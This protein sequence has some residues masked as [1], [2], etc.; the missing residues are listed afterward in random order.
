VDALSEVL[1]IVK[2]EGAF[3]FN[4]EFSSPWCVT[5]PCAV[6]LVPVLAPGSAHLITFH[7]LTEGQCTVQVQGEAEVKL[8]AGDIIIIPH[9]DSHKL[10]NGPRSTAENPTGQLE[11]ILEHGLAPIRLGGGGEMTRFVCGYMTC[12]AHICDV[13]LQGLPSSFK[14]NIFGD[15]S[16]RWLENS[17]KFMVEEANAS[18]AG[19]IAVLAKLSEALFA[20]ALRRYVAQLPSEQT[21]WLGAARDAEV[22]KAL[23]LLHRRPA[24]SWTIAEL[25][26]EVGVSRSAL[27][28]RFSHYLGEPPITYLTKWR[29]TLGAQKLKTSNE[30]VANVA[31]DV[32]YESEPAF[33]RAF[34]RA[35]GLPPARFRSEAKK[36]R[37]AGIRP[38]AA[39]EV[40]QAVVAAGE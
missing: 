16:G 19:G 25:A 26:K 22:G 12:D 20:E 36:P 30:S 38:Q 23:T 5:T 40:P 10:W 8:S 9:G 33:N 17:L 28:E 11:T 2:L 6:D 27:V 1:K 13:V 35:F 29:L 39:A 4:A 21:G 37:S 34:K 3:Y 14:V 31:A 24:H 18:R 32:G 7:L 15:S